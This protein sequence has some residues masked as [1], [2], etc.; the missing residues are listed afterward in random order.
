MSNMHLNIVS[1]LVTSEK[2]DSVTSTVS[3]IEQE[4]ADTNNKLQ[5]QL[6]ILKEHQVKGITT[7]EQVV[8]LQI[9]S[10]R[11]II[12]GL[13]HCSQMCAKLEK[14]IKRKSNAWRIIFGV[15][16]AVSFTILAVI[17]AK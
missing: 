17:A 13:Q 10:N 14:T 6:D 7:I 11:T 15:T 12:E 9:E 2:F 4:L 1:D 8:K 3:I 5:S 16:L